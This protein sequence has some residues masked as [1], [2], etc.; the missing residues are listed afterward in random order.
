MKG[1]KTQINL[2]NLEGGCHREMWNVHIMS[3]ERREHEHSWDPPFRTGVQHSGLGKLCEELIYIS[4]VL[5]LFILFY[6]VA[7]NKEKM[8]TSWV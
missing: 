3:K 5:K 2:Q 8:T 1:S 7:Y 6:I 4:H